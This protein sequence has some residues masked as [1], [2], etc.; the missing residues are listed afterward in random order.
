MNV[1]VIM[2]QTSQS[3]GQELVAQRMTAELNR[4]GHRAYLITSRFHDSRA[5]IS[6]VELRSSG[7][8]V[9]RDNDVLGIPVI[10]VGS[11][12][13][14]WP[15]RRINFDDFV[16]T[17]DRLVGELDLDVLITHSTLWN[18]PELVAGFVAWRRKMSREEAKRTPLLFCHMSHYQP[19]IAGRYSLR[20][21]TYREVW[22]EHSLARVVKEA[23]LLLITTPAAGRAMIDLGAKES[24]LFLF[25]GGIVIPAERTAGQ[26]DRFREEHGLPAVKLVSYLGTIEERKNPMAVIAVAERVRQRTDLHF[27]LAGKLESGYGSRVKKASQ[28]LD[29]VSVLGEMSEG[30][31][32]SL[33][34]ASYL[35]LTM[36]K[37]E[38]LGLAQLE[39]MSAGVP[40]I[41]SGVGGQSWVVRDGVTGMVLQGPDDIEG[42]AQA[43]VQFSENE[44]WRNQLGSNAL[45]FASDLSMEHLIEELISRLQTYREAASAEGAAPDPSPD[46]SL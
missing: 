32:S 2:Y 45:E 22:N 26:L 3:K 41:T 33:I 30:E 25:P 28:H 15:P 34:R 8:A 5:L 42:A 39:F 21:R 43:V 27:V 14:E 23:D 13:A 11:S 19:P 9:I 7:G 31:K 20:E 12:P 18:G 10:R 1:G 17:L 40:V 36:S 29:N 44:G 4:Q 6:K 46:D 38:A 37:L 35:N 24:Q 16:P